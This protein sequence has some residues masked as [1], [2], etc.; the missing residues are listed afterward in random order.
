MVIA[1][2]YILMLGL[3]HN[4]RTSTFRDAIIFTHEVEE[5]SGVEPHIQSQQ[6]VHC[7]ENAG[8]EI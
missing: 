5:F 3:F 4:P 1:T 8:K 7:E 6:L 2:R